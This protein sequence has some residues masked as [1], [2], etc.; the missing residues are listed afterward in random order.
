[1]EPSKTFLT[2]QKQLADFGKM[3]DAA[4]K[5]NIENLENIQKLYQT[6]HAEIIEGQNLDKWD[7]QL[8][9]ALQVIELYFKDSSAGYEKL[10]NELFYLKYL[11]SENKK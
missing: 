6:A 7:S 5:E 3:L 10:K 9:K 2:I 8:T 4:N 11:I 1:M